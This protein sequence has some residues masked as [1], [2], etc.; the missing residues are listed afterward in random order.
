VAN[1]MTFRCLRGMPFAVS[2]LCTITFAQEHPKGHSAADMN[3]QFQDP[4]LDVAK[5]VD[6]FE[7]NSRDI[8]AQRKQIVEAIG[9]RPGQAIADIGAGTGLFTWMFAEKVGPN[10]TVYAVEIA[11]AFLK[12][13]ADQA[14]KRG[15][16]DVVKT[17]RS[18]QDSANLA[19]GS[20]D[21]AFVCATYHHFEHPEKILASIHHALRPGGRLVVIE[22]DLRK[23]SSTFVREHARAPK[24][25]YFREIEA[26]GFTRVDVKGSPQLKDNFF[27]VFDRKDS[28]APRTAKAVRR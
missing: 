11:P 20:L 3:K 18:T 7:S 17:A 19:P 22:F 16:Q 1:S 12:Y 6:R 15:L 25:V 26:T 9:L 5:F 8:F 2:V 24:D 14:T 28:A 21:V 13:L 23:D 10:G 27:A 4:N